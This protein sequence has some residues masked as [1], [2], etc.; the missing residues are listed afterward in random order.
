[1]LDVQTVLYA[2]L[3]Q[4]ATYP[5]QI[6]LCQGYF[7]L[8]RHTHSYTLS[9]NGLKVRSIRPTDH[10]SLNFSDGNFELAQIPLIT[11]PSSLLDS[12]SSSD[13]DESIGLSSGLV[14]K[15]TERPRQPLR[16]VEGDAGESELGLGESVGDSCFTA[17]RR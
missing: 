7:D 13:G 17:M 10:I 16:G 14:T 15:S 5:S 9:A 6:H 3:R 2:I 11:C 12:Q 4:C 1:M 8:A